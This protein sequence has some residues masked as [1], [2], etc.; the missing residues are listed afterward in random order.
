MKN[1]SAGGD[2]MGTVTAV[3]G[4]ICCG[5]TFFSSR[6]IRENGGVLLSCDE[7][8]TMIFR[9]QLG[10]KHDET[11]LLVKEYLHKKAAEIA[12]AGCDVVLDWGFW[13]KAERRAVTEYY[14]SRGVALDW[15]Y[16]SITDEEWFMNIAERNEKIES[17]LSQDYYIDQGLLIKAFTLFEEPDGEELKELG[18]TV[19]EFTR[20]G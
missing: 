17:G 20:E 11:M 4:K 12:L 13:A 14:R 8:S 18:F 2:G 9:Q 7:I 19:H 3:C 1:I 5:K 16:I 6:L 15:H 10:E